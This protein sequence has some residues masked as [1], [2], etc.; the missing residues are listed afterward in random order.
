MALA[1]VGL[2]TITVVNANQT[3]AVYT[4]GSGQTAFVRGVVIHSQDVDNTIQSE[5][6][7]VPN[8]GGSAGA[9]STNTRLAVLGIST[10]DTY[11]L[12]WTYPITMSNNGDTIQV[13]N[14]STQKALNVIVL[15]DREL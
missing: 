1:Q 11:F 12:E 8:V 5:I 7:Y 3:T 13:K 6:H 14:H 4:V 9:A 10:T 15:G 2:G